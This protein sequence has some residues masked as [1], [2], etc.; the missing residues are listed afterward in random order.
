MD[1]EIIRSVSGAHGAS[2]IEKDQL[3]ISKFKNK[4]KFKSFKL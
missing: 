2:A 3:Q 1:V 4:F